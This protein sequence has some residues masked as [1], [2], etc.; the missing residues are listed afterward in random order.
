M[1][2]TTVQE[3]VAEQING[4]QIAGYLKEEAL[5]C[6]KYLTTPKLKNIEKNLTCFCDYL[7]F[8]NQQNTEHFLNLAEKEPKTS[9]SQ[10]RDLA[11]FFAT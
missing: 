6:L 1:T 8:L 4:L 7:L 5:A 10:S 2:Q 9:A 11:Y 3:R